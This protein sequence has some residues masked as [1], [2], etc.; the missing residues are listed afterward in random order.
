[1][2][3]LPTGALVV[4]TG[5]LLPLM[6]VAAAWGLTGSA[7]LRILFCKGKVHKARAL[8][9]FLLQFIQGCFPIMYYNTGHVEKSLTG[10]WNVKLYWRHQPVLNF[11]QTFGDACCLK[12]E[13]TLFLITLFGCAKREIN[14]WSR[15]WQRLLVQTCA[16]GQSWQFSELLLLL[17]RALLFDMTGNRDMF[18][19]ES[20]GGILFLNRRKVKTKYW[21]FSGIITHINP[22]LTF[23][24]RGK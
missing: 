4:A 23:L 10:L 5:G 1:M 11:N 7:S 3:N 6:I 14:R 22:D 2:C 20:K 24:Q 21:Q 19:L 13:A 18:C 15:Q 12:S 17:V 16:G 8:C 9:W